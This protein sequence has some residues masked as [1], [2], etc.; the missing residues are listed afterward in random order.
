M[1]SNQ[2]FPYLSFFFSLFFHNLASFFYN[3]SS[4]EVTKQ[5]PENKKKK[6]LGLQGNF[7][8]K[9]ELCIVHET[10]GICTYTPEKH[11]VFP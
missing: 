10:N 6:K 11:R 2:E 3:Q 7:N 9:M 5:N 4:N 8:K 1:L